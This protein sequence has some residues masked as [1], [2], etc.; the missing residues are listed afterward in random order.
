VTHDP[1]VAE[2]T[3]SLDELLH[4]ADVV[5]LHAAASTTTVGMIGIDEFEAMRDGV[6]YLNTARADLH[7]VDA[8]VGALRSGKVGAAGLDHFAGENL[9]PDHP[10]TSFDNVI[11]T[12][13]IG[14]ATFDT[15]LN[16]TRLI[17]ED[18][19]RLLTGVPPRHVANPEV[20]GARQMGSDGTISS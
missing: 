17:A 10:L 12:P 4:E 2:A 6:V 8:L 11:L 1:H 20:L 9:A 13:H 19:Y 7:D 16:H 15:E 5:S 14:G 3:H 18:L